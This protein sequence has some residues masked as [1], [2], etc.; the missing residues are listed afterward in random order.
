MSP[1]YGSPVPFRAHIWRKKASNLTNFNPVTF[2][3]EEK[4]VNH[5]FFKPVVSQTAILCKQPCS[6]RRNPIRQCL[7]RKMGLK[8]LIHSVKFNIFCLSQPLGALVLRVTQCENSMF[9]FPHK[10]CLIVAVFH[11]RLGREES[12]RS[13]NNCGV[14][15]LNLSFQRIPPVQTAP[16]H[17]SVAV[18]FNP[19]L[20][21]KYWEKLMGG[22]GWCQRNT[23]THKTRTW[24][25]V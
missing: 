19:N 9:N 20:W 11:F 13:K 8:W 2:P 21:H 24:D 7:L 23:S 12:G 5:T 4:S 18:S 17:N 3:K 25:R 1:Y 22:I 14:R 16:Q 6:N 15:T 10:Y